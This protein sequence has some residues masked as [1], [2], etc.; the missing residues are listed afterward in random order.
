MNSIFSRSITEVTQNGTK[1]L[2]VGNF[3]I[4]LGCDMHSLHY[5]ETSGWTVMTIVASGI[6]YSGAMH[7]L[8]YSSRQ[9]FSV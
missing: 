2:K 1:N 5:S 8:S 7:S 3:K 6:M 9:L 4:D